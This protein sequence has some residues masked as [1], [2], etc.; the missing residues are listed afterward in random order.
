LELAGWSALDAPLAMRR[1]GSIGGRAAQCYS[2]IALPLV[3]GLLR[4][5]EVLIPA[6]SWSHPDCAAAAVRDLHDD[7]P[8]AALAR[9]EIIEHEKTRLQVEDELRSVR[10]YIA[11]LVH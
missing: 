9:L 7:V 5:H 8:P 1:L 6:E 2:P 11:S 10:Q 4:G 3:R